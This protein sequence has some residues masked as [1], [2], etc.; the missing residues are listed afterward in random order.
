M[1]EELINFAKQFNNE[2]RSE[3]H[4]LESFREE[5]FVT[6][7]GYILDEYGETD[8]VINSSYQNKKQ[9]IKVDG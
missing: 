2:I 6:R 7:M 1:S 5:V 4:A 3:S 8:E 9:G